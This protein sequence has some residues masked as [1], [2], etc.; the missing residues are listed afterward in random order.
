MM[1]LAKI[2][3]RQVDKA[4]AL[5]AASCVVTPQHGFV[6]GRSINDEIYELEGSFVE[7][8]FLGCDGAMFFTDFQAAFPSLDR[9]FVFSA[10]RRMGIPPP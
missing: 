4:L 9:E 10:L 6:S 8:S 7:Y 2:L 3:A 5:I 1:M